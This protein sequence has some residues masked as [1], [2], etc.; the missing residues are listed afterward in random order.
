MIPLAAINLNCA[1]FHRHISYNIHVI[2]FICSRSADYPGHVSSKAKQF[3]EAIAF[4]F[5]FLMQPIEITFPKTKKRL[6][7]L[8]HVTREKC[9]FI[10][11]RYIAHN[12]SNM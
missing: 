5:A 9:N 6:H 8:A 12:T 2:T 4:Y 11:L 3:R 7:A 10:A 1:L